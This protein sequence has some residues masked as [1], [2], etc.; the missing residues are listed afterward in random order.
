MRN[1]LPMILV[2]VLVLAG[3][4]GLLFLGG[5][6][7]D[8]RLDASVIG[9][10]GL[11]TWL[12]AEGLA[13]ER[14]NPR[15]RPA[16]S[17]LAFRVLPLYDTDL[18]ADPPEAKTPRDAYYATTLRNIEAWNLQGRL[19]DMPALVILPKWV[20]GTVTSAM[21]H[22]S[23]LIPLEEAGRLPGQ[24]GNW[25]LLL[26]RPE[27]GFVTEEVGQDRVALF[28]PQLFDPAALPGQCS[29]VVGLERGILVASCA[30]DED[31]RYPL[32]LLSDPDLMNNH[33]LA[34]ADNAAVAAWLFRAL[35]PAAATG[36]EEAPRIYID[37][38]AENM[39]DYYNYDEQRQDYDRSATDFARFFAPPLTGLWAVLAILLG[40]ALWRGARRFGPAQ[41]DAADTPEQSKLAAIATNARLLRIAGHDAR[42]A[43]DLVQANLSDLAQT[44]F[45]RA[46][47][48]GPQGIARLFA[49]LSRRD[50]ARTAE[51]Q[52]VAQRLTDTTHPL[53][54]AELHRQLDAFRRLLETLTHGK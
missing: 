29:A 1:A 44:T 3:L 8:R 16:W 48:A 33:G 51:L 18:Y 14:S 26:I 22:D 42:M 38:E 7:E 4:A 27:Q 21:A 5:G 2:G 40:L 10:D 37:T 23:A 47:G 45:G 30:F 39:V 54:P 24:I 9:I 31:D 12:K 36:A 15:F 19:Y 32:Y 52:A 28:H 41:A 49:H 34:L 35:A 6:R 20:A 25:S 43:A 50:P 11:A 46:V 13:V 17:Q 53:S